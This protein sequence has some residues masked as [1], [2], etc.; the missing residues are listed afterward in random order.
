MIVTV[1]ESLVGALEAIMDPHNPSNIAVFRC[2][3]EE[4]PYAVL[5]SKNVEDLN[6][7]A[8]VLPDAKSGRVLRWPSIR[9]TVPDPQ[10][11]VDLISQVSVI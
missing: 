2:E 9:T 6:K 11:V 3:G 4:Y 8:E 1:V 10:T 7:V 5:V